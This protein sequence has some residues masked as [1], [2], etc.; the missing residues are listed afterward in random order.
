MNDRLRLLFIDDEPNVTD[1]LRRTLRE[2]RDQ[3]EVH[4]CNDPLEA[5]ARIAVESFDTIVTDIRMPGLDGFQ[6]IERVRAM[7]DR[8]EVPIVVLT[9]NQ[10]SDQKRR[11]LDLGATD[12]LNKPVEPADLIARLRSALRIKQQQDEL[13]HYS[14]HLESLVADRTRD[15]EASRLDIL[16]RLGNAA[17]HRD[18][19]TGLHVVRVGLYTRALAARLGLPAAEQDNLFLTSPLHDV[20]KIGIPDEILLK[21]GRLTST[22]FAQM[23]THTTIGAEILRRESIGEQVYRDVYRQPLLGVDN[24]LLER[25]AVIALSHHERWDGSGYPNRV[26]GPEIPLEGRLVA[27]ADV[28]DALSS[29]RPYKPALPEDEVFRIMSEGAGSHFDPEVFAAFLSIR[30]EFREIR[31]TYADGESA[32]LEVAVT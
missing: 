32:P 20:G 25:S 7:P 15:L 14:L 8:R 19:D 30:E 29:L 13:R 10:E 6:L 31:M 18:Q 28:Y 17:E 3:W 1:A 12:L 23:Q 11:A 9:G 2:F 21:P 4:T 16:W 5:V 24:P 22:E 26:P 27:V